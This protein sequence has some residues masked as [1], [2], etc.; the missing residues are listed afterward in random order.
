MVSGRFDTLEDGGSTARARARTI[1]HR[2]DCS[3]ANTSSENK[4]D[5]APK[6]DEV[7][8]WGHS[9]AIMLRW[10]AITAGC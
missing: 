4:P 7:I 10:R 6:P 8:A 5:L 9:T 1:A 3:P 2:E